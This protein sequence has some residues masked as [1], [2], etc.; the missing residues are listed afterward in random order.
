M[1]ATFRNFTCSALAARSCSQEKFWYAHNNVVATAHNPRGHTLGI[2]GLGDIGYMIAEKAKAA[3]GMKIVYHDVMRK[4]RDAENKLEAEFFEML[5]SMLAVADCTI[6]ATPYTG[7]ILIGRENI[8]KLKKGS[9]LVNIARGGLLDEPAL[10]DA[11]KA[12]DLHAA[13][14]DVHQNEPRV[15]P[16]LA[17]MENVTLTCHSAGGALETAVGFER[18]AMEN[19]MAV[20]SGREP[21]TP[22]N[23]HLLKH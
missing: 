18:L 21:I 14:L 5:D 4:S 3:F 23:A 6:I 22:V 20:L 12:G 7:S 15:N 8:S 9:R 17:S 16:V 10:I 13:A 11:L 1:L 2:I 19:I